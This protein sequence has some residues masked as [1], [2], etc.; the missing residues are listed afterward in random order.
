MT[1]VLDSN[2]FQGHETRQ[3]EMQSWDGVED[4]AVKA[5]RRKERGKQKNENKVG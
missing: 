2:L 5:K 3:K 4:W 1:C